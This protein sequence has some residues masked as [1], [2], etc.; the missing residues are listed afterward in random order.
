MQSK[1]IE[2]GE[3]MNDMILARQNN[4]ALELYRNALIFVW[5]FYGYG[6]HNDFKTSEDNSVSYMVFEL[7]ACHNLKE[8]IDILQRNSPFKINEGYAEITSLLV[9]IFQEVLKRMD[10]KKENV[11]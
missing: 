9:S 3:A 1:N 11:S 2:I 10:E 7:D 8:L 6:T 4:N 5:E